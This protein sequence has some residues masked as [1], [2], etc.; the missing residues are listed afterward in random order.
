MTTGRLHAVPR[1]WIVAFPDHGWSR[2]G[3]PPILFSVPRPLCMFVPEIGLVS[4]T[5]TRWDIRELLP[6]GTR[7][8]GGAGEK[9]RRLVASSSEP[10][11]EP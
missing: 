8:A 2:I 3:P 4:E 6:G 11:R 1:G 10:G 9:G 5:F 7:Q